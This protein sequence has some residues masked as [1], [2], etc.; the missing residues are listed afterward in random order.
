MGE[1]REPLTEFVG[2]VLSRYSI[3][4]DAL[5]EWPEPGDGCATDRDYAEL[6]IRRALIDRDDELD[7]LRARLAAAEGER[8][9]ALRI[10][11]VDLSRKPTEEERAFAKT[12]DPRPSG[13]GKPLCFNKD[14]LAA[15][16][17]AER[18]E[19]LVREAI[20]IIEGRPPYGP[21][22]YPEKARAA[23]ERGGKA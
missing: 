9:A 12:I 11:G 15:E 5:Y 14:H 19:V 21:F 10:A 23:L 2:Q 20:D 6:C 18:L 17:R 8:D 1:E 16:S 3:E 7:A 4:D 22:L 13:K